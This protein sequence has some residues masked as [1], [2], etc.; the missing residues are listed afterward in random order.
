MRKRPIKTPNTFL[1]RRLDLGPNA[2]SDRIQ[3]YIQVL[4]KNK[5]I[6]LRVLQKDCPHSDWCQ[7]DIDERINLGILK[8]E[9]A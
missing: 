5:K 4:H 2:D 8:Y 9:D 1:D 3:F 7:A 6:T